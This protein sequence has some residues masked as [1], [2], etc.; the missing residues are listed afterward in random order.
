MHD[1]IQ[2]G[3]RVVDGFFH[4]NPNRNGENHILLP[5]G[6]IFM[7]ASYP[8]KIVSKSLSGIIFASGA[9]MIAG[10]A[11]MSGLY[12]QGRSEVVWVKDHLIQESHPIITTISLII[13][14]AFVAI[15]AVSYQYGLLFGF[16]VGF[17]SGLN[18]GAENQ[19]KRS[20]KLV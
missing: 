5:Q 3:F 9:G 13:I 1:I 6:I 4:G 11:T 12:W 15:G 16:A 7:C 19:E 18:I 2:Q 17:Y 20:E 14:V 10:G 8:L